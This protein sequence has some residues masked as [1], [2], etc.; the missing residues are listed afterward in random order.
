MR[1]FLLPRHSTGS[2]PASLQENEKYDR[3]LKT[4]SSSLPA[5][6]LPGEDP[7]RVRLVLERQQAVGQG[8]AT[9]DH[10]FLTLA[11]SICR[12]CPVSSLAQEHLSTGCP[13]VAQMLAGTSAVLCSG[14]CVLLAVSALLAIVTIFLPGGTCERRICTLAGYMQMAAAIATA[15]DTVPHIP[16]F[17]SS[18]LA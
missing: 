14:G 10:P 9:A 18:I 17:L 16:C 6:R 3:A 12:Q 11:R 15:L 2:S 4:T 13:D 1:R 8:A 5:L 7:V